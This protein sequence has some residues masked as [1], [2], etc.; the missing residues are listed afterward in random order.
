KTRPQCVLLLKL[1]RGLAVPRRLEGFMVDLGP[2]GERARFGFRAGTGRPHRTSPAVFLCKA[3]LDYL[4]PSDINVGLPLPTLFALW[5]R[6]CVGLPVFLKGAILIASALPSLPAWVGSYRP[7]DG[8]PIVPGT[9]HEGFGVRVATVNQMVPWEQRFLGEGRM[10]R[11]QHVV[12]GAGRWGGFHMRDH[13][14]RL[15]VTRLGRMRLVADPSQAPLDAVTRLQIIRGMDKPSSRW[16]VAVA[17]PARGILGTIVLL[18]PDLAE[19]PHRRRCS[20]LRGGLGR[21]GS[22]E[23]GKPISA[24]DGC[25]LLPG[26]E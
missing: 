5:T 19:P 22:V 6:G 25:E 13:M 21:I 8:H 12:I 16:D 18:Y 17:P 10:D 3:D 4:L 9:R 2:D 15:G 1:C 11:L 23:E 20:H 24:D 14:G 7:H 26:S